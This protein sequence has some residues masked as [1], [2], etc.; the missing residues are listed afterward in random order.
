MGVAMWRLIIDEGD[1]YWN[2]AMDEAMLLLRDAN[3]I[4][5]TLRIYVIKPSAVTIGYSQSVE[6]AVDLEFLK[7]NNISFTRRISGGGSVYHDANGEITYSIVASISDIS[8]DVVESFR[9]ICRGIVYAIKELGVNAEFVP[10]N[11]VVINGRKVSGNAQARKKN[12]LLQHGTLMY[13]TDLETLSKALKAPK[14]KLLRH[15]VTTILER[16]T[17][18]SRELGRTVSKDDV[19]KALIKGFS[20]AL[21]VNFNPGQYTHEE[22]ELARKLVE[23][24]KSD[25]WIFKGKSSQMLQYLPK[26]T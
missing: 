6:E 9:I 14:D 16:V 13:N 23:K 12:A 7:R 18:V 24:Y 10:I 5:N 4:P 15:G 11:D 3:A 8:T 21:N 22:L 19:I 25:E 1:V 17:T 20:K 2:M 26:Q